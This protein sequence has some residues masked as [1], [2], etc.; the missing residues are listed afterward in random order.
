[1]Q[2]G[3]QEGTL[4]TR[5]KQAHAAAVAGAAPHA[6]DGVVEGPEPLAHEAPVGA[7]GA[8]EGLHRPLHILWQ[9]VKRNDCRR[10]AAHAHTQRRPGRHPHARKHK[11]PLGN[12]RQLRA[13]TRTRAYCTHE[14]CTREC[15]S[16][17]FSL[18]GPASSS[19]AR[20]GSAR[21]QPCLPPSP[22]DARRGWTQGKRSTRV[23]L[24]SQTPE[25]KCSTCLHRQDS[26]NDN[27]SDSDS[28]S[29][30]DIDI[31]ID[32]DSGHIVKPRREPG[33]RTTEQRKREAATERA[34]DGVQLAVQQG[35]AAGS[36]T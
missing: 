2:W 28:D 26:D 14:Y 27:D 3:T 35:H 9:H 36:T 4:S 10:A 24:G 13:L 17:G 5:A 12:F 31:D 20:A 11:T 7:L 34:G 21:P 18:S 15:C 22:T 16:R 8:R 32:S 23:Y 6:L 33:G 25:R 19:A 1:M 30:S 29:D